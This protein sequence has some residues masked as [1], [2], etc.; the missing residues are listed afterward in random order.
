M[1]GSTPA[2]LASAMLVAA[3]MSSVAGTSGAYI[4]FAEA[5][6]V[7][8]SLRSDLLPPELQKK[9]P[10]ELEAI[11]PD[12]VTGH[13]RAIRAR[14]DRGND[15]S[16]VNFLF[17]GVTFTAEP[18]VKQNDIGQ[19][20]L[21]G[22]S[23]EIARDPIVRRRVE[24]MIAGI[25]A[26]GG[27]ERLQFARQIVERKGIDPGDAAGRGRVR[28]FLED[29]VTR[30]LAENEQRILH[31]TSLIEQRDTS[32]Q[33]TELQTFFRDRGLSSD[34]SI[35]I[36]F[37][38]AGALADVESQGVLTEGSVRRAAILGPGLDFTDK[39][40]G[41]D[42]YPQQTLQ[43]FATFDS[44][45]R[46]GLARPEALRITTFDLNPRI[47][48]HLEAARRRAGAGGAYVLQLPRDS[49]PWTPAL[50]T[51]WQQF[52]GKIGEEVQALPVPPAAGVVQVRA[53]RIR[54]GIVTSIVPQD[55][56]VVLQRPSVLPPGERFDLI[57]ATNILG[58]YDLFE[59]SLA[60]ANLSGLLRPGG[61]L[62]T[63][64]EIVLLP[65]TPMRRVGQR[66]VAYSDGPN[67]GDR[68]IWYQRE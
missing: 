27:N 57:V 47:N 59:Q 48:E 53:V 9:T 67:N 56:N 43:P 66:D 52:G 7:L 54:P 32:A 39:R 20:A 19:L 6:P 35:F 3:L 65:T 30:V 17:F 5:K 49:E 41:F 45:V 63:N 4:S 64:N 60:V 21:K 18:R 42:F 55:L 14:L 51:F 11:W 33:L 62:L 13:D 37:A 38:V 28:Q 8:Q 31:I 23:A 2:R 61:V 26:P 29:A 22:R 16:I 58:Y 44:L 50:V 36:D 68:L 15:D 12:W 34:T 46:V 25:A 24:D 10:A 40:D 1:K